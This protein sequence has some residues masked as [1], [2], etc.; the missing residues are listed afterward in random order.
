M[1]YASSFSP[2]PVVVL[3]MLTV[4]GAFAW[5]LYAEPPPPA[6]QDS[7]TR[8]LEAPRSRVVLA[9]ETTAVSEAAELSPAAGAFS[10][11]T[12]TDA[13]AAGEVSRHAEA[14]RKLAELRAALNAAAGVAD[15][16]RR[17]ETLGQLCSQWAEFDPRGAVALACQFH[18]E[19]A[20]VL[21]NLTQQWAGV[22]LPAAR[23]WIDAQ[24]PSEIRTHLVARI[25]FL[26]AQIEPESAANY[27]FD[28]MPPG[29]IQ[30]EAAISVLHQWAQ[31]D[32]NAAMAWARQFAAGALRERALREALLVV[33]HGGAD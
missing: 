30:T 20:G 9:G 33:A 21:E 31:R 8:A 29:E 17:N 15:L 10:P 23:A 12:I 4:I 32:R 24:P 3:S 28:E 19:E 26:W 6:A 11:A 5:V 2:W 16:Q 7:V 27:I 25:G 13:Q 1:Q 14:A 22:D 18:L